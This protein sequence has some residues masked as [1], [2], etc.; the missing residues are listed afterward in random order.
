MA[1]SSSSGNLHPGQT[2]AD[3]SMMVASAMP[4]AAPPC[5][6]LSLDDDTL[7]VPPR[8]ERSS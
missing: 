2:R 1:G 8:L 5:R 4:A 3:Y 7:A 6:L